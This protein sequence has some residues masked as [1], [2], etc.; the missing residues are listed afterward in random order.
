M[1]GTGELVHALGE[2]LSQEG[3]LG[4][5][6][7]ICPPMPY[8][9]MGRNVF[10]GWVNLG[11]QNVSGKTG[12]GAWTGEVSSQILKSSL[13][14]WV[15]VGHSERRQG[16]KEQDDDPFILGD[17]IKSCWDAKIG[18][19]YCIGESLEIRKNGET[20]TKLKG[21]LEAVFT[22]EM[23][24][25]LASGGVDRVKDSL[26]IAYEPIWAIG[27]GVVAT[28]EQVEDVHKQIRDWLKCAMKPDLSDQI[29]I[30]YGGSVSSKTCTA[31]AGLEN[32]Q[33]FLVGGA[34]LSPADFIAIIRSAQVKTHQ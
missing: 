32:V 14:D 33:G 30:L 26:V 1:N 34:S 7:A 10:P 6:V 16:F 29:R 24:E 28:P 5:Q 23:I 22:A 21:Q 17:K 12:V 3:D 27:T 9:L 2:A 20:W 31:L 18:V 19:I 13:V 15:I 8:I 4:V 25:K 11:A